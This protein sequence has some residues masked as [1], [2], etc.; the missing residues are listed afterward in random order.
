MEHV[1]KIIEAY[2][3]VETNAL[4]RKKNHILLNVSSWVGEDGYHHEKYLIGV[5]GG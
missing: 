1:T 4:L 2:S 5:I 3:V